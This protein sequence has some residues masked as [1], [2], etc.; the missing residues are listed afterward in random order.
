MY[1]VIYKSFFSEFSNIKSYSYTYDLNIDVKHNAYSNIYSL[2]Y[3]GTFLTKKNLSINLKIQVSSK[4]SKIA[5]R[6]LWNITSGESFHSDVL[7]EI[8][9]I[10]STQELGNKDIECIFCNR[11]FS[12][13]ERGEIWIKCFSCFLWT[14]LDCTE[15]EIAMHICDFY[16]FE[17]EMVF[18]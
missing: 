6:S 5:C 1:F 18:T 2:F 3:C 13:D 15:A 8:H 17:V 11:K 10:C 4:F 12:K 9:C 7:S 16:R 14:Q